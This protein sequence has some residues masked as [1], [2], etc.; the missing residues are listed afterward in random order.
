MKAVTR[1]ATMQQGLALITGLVVLV[2]LTIL[3]VSIMNTTILGTRM[4]TNMQESNRA[5]YASESGLQRAF[6]DPASYN[7][8]LK[9]GSSSAPITVAVDSFDLTLT[10]TY[11][12]RG[13]KV[14][15]SQ[16]F[17]QIYSSLNYRTANFQQSSMAVHGKSNAESLTTQGVTQIIP[18]SR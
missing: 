10:T 13:E 11:T 1:M 3:G 4:A 5:M 9:P 6:K 15:R 8:L 17:G 2:V 7:G 16:K 12:V 14:P 18:R